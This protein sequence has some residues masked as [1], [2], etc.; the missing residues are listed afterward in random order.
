M[1]HLIKVGLHA[2]EN[3]GVLPTPTLGADLAPNP[4]RRMGV[5]QKATLSAVHRFPVGWTGWP[6]PG[7][8]GPW[9]KLGLQCGSQGCARVL[10]SRR[11]HGA[12]HVAPACRAP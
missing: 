3:S 6:E 12:L 4:F 1:S 11:D 10:L 9:P 7:Q 8:A 5:G 2:P